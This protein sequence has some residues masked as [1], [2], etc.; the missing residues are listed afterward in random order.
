[1]RPV[2]PEA[3]PA[4]DVSEN[5]GDAAIF[6]SCSGSRTAPS[7]IVASM[8]ATR[9]VL[10][11]GIGAEV[12]GSTICS[13]CR[14]PAVLPNGAPGPTVCPMVRS[15]RARTVVSP[16]TRR[17][18]DT[19]NLPSAGSRSWSV[20]NCCTASASSESNRPSEPDGYPSAASAP[21][22]A[23]TSSPSSPRLRSRNRGCT[24]ASAT[25]GALSSRITTLPFASG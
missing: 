1:M 11:P 19:R 6:A 14:A 8:P 5:P 16:G 24:A 7:E 25:T 2:S 23:S 15:Q 18:V 22:S 10:S 21:L 3:W 20:W 13:A 9:T 4:C 12:P 17:T